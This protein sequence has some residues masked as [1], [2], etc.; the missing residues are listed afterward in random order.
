MK[1]G[2]FEHSQLIWVQS[3][4]QIH[5]DFKLLQKCK[6]KPLIKIFARFLHKS[7]VYSTSRQT[8]CLSKNPQPKFIRQ[9]IRKKRVICNIC[10]VS[11][12]SLIL[13]LSCKFGR[14]FEAAF[15]SRFL[16]SRVTKILQ[17]NL[18]KILRLKLGQDSEY[19]FWL[20]SDMTL[21]RCCFGKSTRPLG[22][23]CPWQC[24]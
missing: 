13:G 15:W 1:S 16:D 3:E 21:K 4:R 8:W 10:T 11:W 24:L 2:G 7:C 12:W 19:E 20:T 9:K 22:P 17:L 14:D 23:L 18:I 6:A 5:T